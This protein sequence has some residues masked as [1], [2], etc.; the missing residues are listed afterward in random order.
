MSTLKDVTSRAIRTFLQAALAFIT[1]SGLLL[2]FSASGK[3]D[4]DALQVVLIGALFSGLAATAAFLQNWLE[5]IGKIPTIL[6][7]QTVPV[8]EANARIEEAFMSEPNIG[9]AP[10]I[11]TK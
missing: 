6:K 5:T 8:T 4:L 7:P 11:P 1:T 3:I 9:E 2:A 10:V